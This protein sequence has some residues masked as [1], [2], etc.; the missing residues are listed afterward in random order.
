VSA[1]WVA[2]T[3]AHRSDVES[4]RFQNATVEPGALKANRKSI[5]PLLVIILGMLAS[6][7]WSGFLV[8]AGITIVGAGFG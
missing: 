8:W 7:A 1:V 5:W 6:V 3:F 4:N 2:M